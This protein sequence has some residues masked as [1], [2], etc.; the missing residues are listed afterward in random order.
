[1]NKFEIRKISNGWVLQGPRHL[2]KNA[3]ACHVCNEDS[4]VTEEIFL[5]TMHAVADII[6]TWEV[7]GFA[8]AATL[9]DKKY[10]FVGR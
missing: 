3:I 4:M 2:V 10:N 7:A 9:A 5:P 8:K 1:M 6:E